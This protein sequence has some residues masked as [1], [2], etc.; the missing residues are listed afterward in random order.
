MNQPIDDLASLKGKQITLYVLPVDGVFEEDSSGTRVF[1]GIEANSLSASPRDLANAANETWEP[2]TWLIALE[3]NETKRWPA[4]SQ[5]DEET[6]LEIR[7]ILQPAGDKGHSEAYLYP[8]SPD[9]SKHILKLISVQG[10]KNRRALR[11]LDSFARLKGIPT[12]S[13]QAIT[14]LFDDTLLNVGETAVISYDVGQANW[15]AIV[16]VSNCPNHPPTAILFFDCG[17]PSGWN[18]QTLPTP[19]IA[20]FASASPSV[21]LVLSHWDMDHWAGAAAGQPL[22]GSRG[23]AINFTPAALSRTWI[24][25]NQGRGATGQKIRSTAWRLALALYRAGKLVIWPTLLNR[26]N[27]QQGYSIVK[28]V[29]GPSV[30]GK[31]NNSG[32]AMI[33]LTSTKKRPRALTILPGDAD[34]SSLAANYPEISHPDMSFTGLIASHHG[35]K[36]VGMPPRALVYWSKLAV[37]HGSCH[38]HPTP[39]SLAAHK[40]AGWQYQ[41]ETHIRL[42]R[43]LANGIQQ[44]CGSVVLGATWVASHAALGRCRT[45]AA[46]ADICPIQ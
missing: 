3:S 41:Y 13:K 46:A 17:A 7:F 19:A 25:P 10:L 44:D 12:A 2:N 29:P 24:V 11:R 32:L 36:L 1:D 20:P 15:N 31:N 37:S 4:L 27:L 28:C 9:G 14:A 22:Y 23:I 16:D 5:F 40:T 34:Y 38:G 45:C 43:T 6:W 33:V 26:I 18:Y 21:P 30:R 8:P 39:S 35:A 42:H